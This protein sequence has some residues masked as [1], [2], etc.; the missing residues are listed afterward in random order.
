MSLASTVS[1]LVWL[2]GLLKVGAEVQLPVQIQS[3]SKAV[4]QIAANQVYHERK[5]TLRLIVQQGL[6]KV[7]YLPATEQPTDVLQKD[8]L[9][10]NMNTYYPSL[11]C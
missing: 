10:N 11:E 8:Y 9:G 1:E 7:N 2:L 5:N 6:I 3:D 4:I